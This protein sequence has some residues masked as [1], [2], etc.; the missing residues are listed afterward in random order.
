MP[1][2]TLGQKADLLICSAADLKGD[3]GLFAPPQSSAED[4]KEPHLVEVSVS[5]PW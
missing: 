4:Q 3:L 5:L 1:C 2:A